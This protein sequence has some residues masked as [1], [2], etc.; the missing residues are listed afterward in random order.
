M[1]DVCSEFTIKTT[2]EQIAAALG[3]VVD[4]ISMHK[5]WDQRIR[6]SQSAPVLYSKASGV[7]LDK[8]IFPVQP[9]PNSRLSG[10]EGEELKR[11]YDRPTWKKS[12]TEETCLIPL[13]SFYEPVYWGEE[14]GSVMEFA[15]TK[16]DV[17]FV[18]G[19]RIM[20]RV[21][22]TGKINAFTM[23]THTPTPQILEYHHRMLVF[24]QAESA[25]EWIEPTAETAEQRLKFLLKNRYL[26][27]LEVSVDRKMARGWEKRQEQHLHK[28][29]DEKSYEKFLKDEGLNA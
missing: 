29:E 25:R 26:P 8:V 21:P 22:A 7:I 10:L 17:L 11:I 2:P 15:P 1:P 18:A 3:A 5:E 13:T 9:F 19:M 20:P 23:L 6:I 12:F 14:A 27:E 4:N 28:M 24:L 16:D